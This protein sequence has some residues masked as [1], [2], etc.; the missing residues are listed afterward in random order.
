MRGQD[1]LLGQM[2]GQRQ[3]FADGGIANLYN[4]VLG[5]VYNE[6]EMLSDEPLPDGSMGNMNAFMRKV[7]KIESEGGQINPTSSARGDFQI[8]SDT[9][10]TNLRRFNRDGYQMPQ[11]EMLSAFPETIMNLPSRDQAAMALKNIWEHTGSSE[12]IESVMRTGSP[13][14]MY[15]LYMDHHHTG[16]DAGTKARAKR[17]FNVVDRNSDIRATIK[18]INSKVKPSKEG[19]ENLT[20][21]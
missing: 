4:E 14:S 7:K 3:N 20:Y 12:G 1:S 10:D 18:T 19:I 2:A 15:N 8:L 9:V 5:D 11:A 21:R 16:D 13:E 17:I 6:V